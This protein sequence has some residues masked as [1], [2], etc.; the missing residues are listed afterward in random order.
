MNDVQREAIRQALR[1]VVNDILHN[2]HD[3]AER[4]VLFADMAGG[5]KDVAADVVGEYETG[6]R[7][8][9]AS[10]RAGRR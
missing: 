6:F 1:P 10:V 7:E 4:E 9:R 5:I 3:D 2:T 8:G